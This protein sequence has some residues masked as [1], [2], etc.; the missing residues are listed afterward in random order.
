MRYKSLPLAVRAVAPHESVPARHRTPGSHP[1][2]DR[3]ATIPILLLVP[4]LVLPLVPT[5]AASA[6]LSVSGQALAGSRIVV[7][8][9]DF[10]TRQR[11]QLLWDGS[12]SGMPAPRADTAGSFVVGVTVPSTTTPGSHQLS[13]APRTRQ[14]SAHRAGTP[15]ATVVVY[16]GEPTPAPTAAS[17]PT[18]TAAPTATPTAAP[19]AAPTAV[20]TATP[21]PVPTA[22]PTPTAAS[23]ASGDYILVSPAALAALP[24]SGA[25]WSALKARADASAGTPDIANQDEMNDVYVLAKALV[26]ARTRVESYRRDVL[27]NLRAAVGT[28]DGGRTLALGRNLPGYV[29]AADLI[30]LPSY[31]ATFDTQIFRPWLRSLLGKTLTDGRTLRQTHERRPNNWG[32]HAGAARA[33]VAAYL[34]DSA[35][36]ARTAQVFKGWLGDRA[37]YAGFSYGDLSWQCD[38]TR[39]VGIDPTGCSKVYDGKTIV[40]GGALP[41]DMRRGGSFRWPPAETGYPWEAM[42]GVVLQAELL[43]QAGYATW[44]WQ[45]R[46]ILRAA[47]FL[48]ERAGWPATGDDEW[49]GWLIDYRYGTHYRVAPPANVGKNFGWTDWIYAR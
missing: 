22:V 12:T 1:L 18:P 39:P 45:D 24:T 16:V 36:L 35:E 11:L 21:T 14:G 27:A 32:T 43:Y 49:Q 34:G 6:S 38:P 15:L 10:A 13:A 42:Q 7:T 19:T 28:E 37:S 4:A 23:A 29:I 48:F 47:R 3:L 41:D 8:G 2:R 26:F 25:A 31:D 46:A 17:T 44:S 33:A 5:A 20:P 40:L 9:S 30:D